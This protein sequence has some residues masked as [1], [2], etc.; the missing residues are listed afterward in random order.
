MANAISAPSRNMTI[1]LWVLRVLMAALF[2]F[3]AFAKLTSQPMMVEE[4]GLLPVGQWFRYFTGLL[5][6]VGS[7]AL[8]TPQVSGLGAILLLIVDIGAF[9]AQVLFIHMDWLHTIVIGAIL[10][11]LVYLQRDS[12]SERIGM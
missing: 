9:F 11:A 7:I 8:L 5:E 2:L 10:A 1:V 12:I 4:F 6:L 3:A